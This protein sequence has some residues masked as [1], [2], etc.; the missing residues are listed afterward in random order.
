MRRKQLFTMALAAALSLSV[1]AP[2]F[3]AEQQETDPLSISNAVVTELNVTVDGKDMK[4]TKY[5]DCYVAKLP[6]PQAWH[7]HK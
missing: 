1:S 2:A 3:A 5:E 6:C 4:V 7:H